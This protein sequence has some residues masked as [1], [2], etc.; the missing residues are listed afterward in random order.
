[1][2]SDADDPHDH[3]WNFFT[4]VIDGAY[5]EFFYDR[6]KSTKTPTGSKWDA[7]WRVKVNRRDAGSIAFRKATDIHKVVVDKQIDLEVDETGPEAKA[8]I[9]KAPYTICLMGPRV[10][11]WGFWQSE[12]GQP[13][14]SKF[15]DW[16]RYLSIFPGD[17]RIEGGE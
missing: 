7:F 11:E 6:T 2:R 12:N 4:Y 14:G 8:K 9:E 1:M 5:T 10:R 15:I 17:P 3:P 13:D 16:R